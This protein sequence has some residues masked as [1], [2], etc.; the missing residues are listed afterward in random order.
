MGVDGLRHATD[1]E[2]RSLGSVRVFLPKFHQQVTNT[3]QLWQSRPSILRHGGGWA[4]PPQR[5]KRIHA[6]DLSTATKSP[7]RRE[8]ID[9]FHFHHVSFLGVSF[10]YTS[11]VKQWSSRRH[12]SHLV[13][14]SLRLRRF[15]GQSD[16]AQ[17]P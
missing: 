6:S 13:P 3:K 2:F 12:Q 10:R 1:G 15:A 17:L 9:Q 14:S 7:L 5:V 16:G 8:H 11:S 4:D